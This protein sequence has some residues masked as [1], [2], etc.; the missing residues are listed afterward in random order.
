[1][2]GFSYLSARAKRLNKLFMEVH[3]MKKKY[4]ILV[5]LIGII[6]IG[7]GIFSVVLLKEPA[8]Q[9][10]NQLTSKQDSSSQITDF[11]EKESTQITSQKNEAKE[12]ESMKADSTQLNQELV[13]AT[14]NQNIS[15]IKRLLTAGANVDAVDEKQQTGL[16][17]ATHENNRAMAE[18]FLV[19]GAN[20]NK[21]DVIQDSPF[22]YAGAEGRTDILRMMLDYNPDTTVTNRF[23]GTAL[24]PA[25]EKGHLDNVR[26][27]VEETDV[28]VNHINQPGWT[29][30]LE[31]IVLTNGD[32]TQQQ[33]VQVLLEHGADPNLADANGVR[34][35][36]HANQMGYG[37][38]AEELRNAGGY[39]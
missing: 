14:K 9:S 22:L 28:D 31:A 23:G 13:A 10:E 38:I 20:V 16:L 25:A 2:H 18:L 4:W 8:T 29:A 32:P 7:I 15:E 26:L 27:L 21:Q 30:L 33:I 39:E 12:K 3:I 36:R 37:K 35:L 19:N 24:I 5:C 34:P 11:N 1:M 17:V 6:L